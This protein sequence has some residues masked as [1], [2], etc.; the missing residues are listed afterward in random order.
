[1]KVCAGV[2]RL[3]PL[4]VD[5]HIETL[6]VRDLVNLVAHSVQAGVQPE[7][8]QAYH[9]VVRAEEP[10]HFRP[11]PPL[12]EKGRLDLAADP[13][14]GVIA[15]PYVKLARLADQGQ[16]NSAPQAKPGPDRRL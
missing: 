9:H 13:D 3:L 10:V 5:Q 1:M 2:Q 4:Q 16:T 12:L 7:E 8:P 15:Q 11:H 14:D 6:N